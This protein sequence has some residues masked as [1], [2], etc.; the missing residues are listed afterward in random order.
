MLPVSRPKGRRPP[1]PRGIPAHHCPWCGIEDPDKRRRWHPECVKA[2]RVACFSADQR[3]HVWARD[4]GICAA[5]SVDTAQLPRRWVGGDV[6]YAWDTGAPYTALVA[7]TP[8]QADHVRPL[9]SRPADIPLDRR[10]QWWGLPNLQTLC[11]ICH[12]AKTKWEAAERQRSRSGAEPKGK[13]D[14]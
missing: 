11:L 9:W 10:D 8:W 13:I 2:Y 3:R 14:G 6:R 7:V 4:G 1:M 12:A 5:C